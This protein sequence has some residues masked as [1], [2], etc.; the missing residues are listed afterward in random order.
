MAAMPSRTV[1]VLAL[2]GSGML[3]AQEGRE[4][5]AAEPKAQ[6]LALLESADQVMQEVAQLR[7]WEWKR[8]VKKDVR[9]RDELAQYLQK[10]FAKEYG[11]GK[12]ERTNAWL[13][14]LG[15]LAP[16][17]DL[18]RVM[19]D[20]LLTQIGGFYDPEQQ[21]FFMM[22]EAAG[23]GD[24][25]NRMMIAHELCHALDDQYVDLS[26]LMKPG[27]KEPS[28]DESY[29]IGGVCE[30]SATALMYAWLAK[31]QSEG[32][33]DIA[34][35]A[36]MSEK[37]AAD[38]KVLL[39]APPY[40]L[41]LVANYMV[42]VHFVTKGSG[43]QGAMAGEDTGAA[44]REVAKAMPRS[45]EQLLHP[46]KYWKPEQR[47][48][49]VRLVNDAE[50]A[51]LLAERSGLVVLER[52]TLG[53]LVAALMA[54]APARKMN[55]ALMMRADYWTNKAARGWGGDRMLLLG[56]DKAAEGKPV[57]DAG[58]VWITAWDS[59]DDRKEF[60][61]AVS[62]HRKS[63][64]GFEFVEHGKVAV[65]AFGSARTLKGEVLRALL[66]ACKFEQDGAAWSPGG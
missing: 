3:V 9:T 34:D 8:P 2:L 33:V 54:V 66:E 32:K 17:K 44:I 61:E 21:S 28:E 46:D 64:P 19:T 11:G 14:V 47:D 55:L 12:L 59:E 31:A 53:E 15:L 24:S 65:F 29:V 37:Q 5:K 42:G 22:A 57:Q 1:S 50:V 26:A 52:N 4:T 60:V 18:R 41:L 43:M 30:G 27:G 51:G 7:G 49:P 58:V 25:V 63:S 45:S 20:V 35:M 36:R 40:C 39:Q 62:R 13:Q 23:F 48:E 56:K 16:D 10:M 6:A 38:N